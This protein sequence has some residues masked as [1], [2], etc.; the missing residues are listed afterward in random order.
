MFKKVLVANRGEIALRI[1]RALRDLSIASVA[2]Y[3]EPDRTAQHVRYADEAHSI[4]PAD[5]RALGVEPRTMAAA[6][7]S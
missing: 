7:A 2:V 4:G 3:S 5:A 6:L 1:V